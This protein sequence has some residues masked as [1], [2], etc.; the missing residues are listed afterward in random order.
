MQRYNF[1]PADFKPDAFHYNENSFFINSE[2]EDAHNVNGPV[3]QH[4]E[5]HADDSSQTEYDPFDAPYPDS[6]EAG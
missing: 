4:H 2:Y 5:Q 1:V 6:A 3:E